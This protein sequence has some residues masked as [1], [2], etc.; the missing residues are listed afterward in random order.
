MLDAG[1]NKEHIFFNIH[2]TKPVGAKRKS[3]CKRGIQHHLH[4]GFTMCNRNI[5]P[6]KA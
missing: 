2:P 3:R 6:Q 4:K 1:L 5:L